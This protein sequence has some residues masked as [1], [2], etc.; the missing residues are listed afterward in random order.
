MMKLK[1][2]QA[3]ESLPGARVRRVNPETPRKPFGDLAMSPTY[4]SGS[5]WLAGALALKVVVP[6]LKGF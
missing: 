2:R 5:C 1:T 6:F 3:L 4:H